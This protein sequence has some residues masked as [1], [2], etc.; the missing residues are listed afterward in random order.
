MSSS[1]AGKHAGPGPSSNQPAVAEPSYAE[2]ARTLV[3]LARLGSLSTLSRKQPGFP[4]GSVM[5]YAL[6]ERANPVFLISTMAMHTQNAQ[7]DP[8][9]SLL[10]TQPDTTGDPLGAA[11]VTLIG[12]TLPIP[13]P[14]LAATR[15]L[16]LE[17]H[18]NSKYWVDFEDFSFYRLEAVDVY[19]V[20]GFGVMGWVSGSDYYSAQPDPLA[21]T[22]P[23]IIE[24]V[25]SDHADALIQLVRKFAGIESEEA[26]M[27][28][29]D[30][31]GFHVRLKTEEGMRGARIAF[32]RE[33]RSL[34]EA[35]KVLVEMVAQARGA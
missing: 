29:V 18:A 21:D 24:H 4:F 2:R 1:T 33:V 26:A 6:D 32:L 25:N 5:P 13:A 9:S 16:Y 34:A 19:Y 11:R 12:N 35:R 10:V 28:A 30:R 17:R 23:G 22:A 20:G 8:R 31:L 27:T 3:Y 7:A 15:N 14:E